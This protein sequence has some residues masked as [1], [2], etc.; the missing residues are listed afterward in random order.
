MKRLCIY[1]ITAAFL[2]T[3]GGLFTRAVYAEEGSSVSI[4]IGYTYSSTY[5]WRGAEFF[6]DGVGVHWGSIGLDYMG[7]SLLF[8]A[9]LNED[10]LVKEERADKDAAKTLHELDYVVSYT[11]ETDML[12]LGLGVIYFQYPYYDEVDSTAVDPSFW[13]GYVTFGLKTVLNPKVE[14]YYDYFVEARKNT[15]GEELPVDEDYYV[16]FSLSQ[17]LYKK[18]GFAFSIS[19]WAGYYNNAYFKARGW[20]DAGGTLGFSKEAG[21]VSFS[22]N[23]Y[24]ARSLTK[25][26]QGPEGSIIKNHFWCDF[27]I[28]Y[29]L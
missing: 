9:G 16:K 4:P 23:L 15:T 27:G 1:L 2:F 20:S 7:F 17:E 6:G 24:Y 3:S 10:H 5:W 13:E 26:F 18:D 28:G 19:T 25:D 22:S 29:T 21:S 12:A 8:A 11:L 14:F